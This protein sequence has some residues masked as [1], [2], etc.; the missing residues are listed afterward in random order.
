M[1]QKYIDLFFDDGTLKLSSFESNR[2]IEDAI[3]KDKN[4]GTGDHF[5]ISRDRK[6]V[7]PMKARAFDHRMFCT[8]FSADTEGMMKH[9]N[10]NGCFEIINT[11]GFGYEVA[12]SLEQ[13]QFGL[14]GIVTYKNNCKIYLPLERHQY[15]P[16]LMNDVPPNEILFL[17][18]DFLGRTN[19]DIFFTKNNQFESEH[20]YR[21]TW[22]CKP[23][24]SIYI[25][26]PGAIK[27]CRKIT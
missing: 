15:L 25:K 26:C 23:N 17:Y 7:L 21:F 4:E 18:L 12:R 5:V 19:F 1:D 22:K 20:E 16:D 11:T 13:F 2:N 9:F 8:S 6:R 14:E 24:H 3:R 10:K 27:Y